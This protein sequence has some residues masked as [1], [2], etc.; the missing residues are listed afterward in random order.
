MGGKKLKGEPRF[1][2]ILDPYETDPYKKASVKKGLVWNTGHKLTK[3]IDQHRSY[4]SIIYY[5]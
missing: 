4:R 5:Q 2:A 1:L 3:V